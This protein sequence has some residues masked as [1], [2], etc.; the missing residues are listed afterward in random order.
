MSLEVDP[1]LLIGPRRTDSLCS[2]VRRVCVS[3]Q[4]SHSGVCVC[5]CV[6]VSGSYTLSTEVC[7]CVS[8]CVRVC[9]LVWWECTEVCS[10]EKERKCVCVFVSRS[11]EHTSELQSHLNVV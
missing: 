1:C 4:I 7:V 11:E 6:C 3:L 8:V 5:V 9:V 10:G 2:S